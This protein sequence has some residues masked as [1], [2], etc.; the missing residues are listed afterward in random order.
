MVRPKYAL[1]SAK[2]CFI[3]QI[4]IKLAR[5]KLPAPDLDELFGLLPAVDND[6]NRLVSGSLNTSRLPGAY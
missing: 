3:S 5:W 4:L 2:I 1:F 6:F